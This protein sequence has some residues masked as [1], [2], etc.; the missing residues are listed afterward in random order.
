VEDFAKTVW[1]QLKKEKS[2]KL[3]QAHTHA[4]QHHHKNTLFLKD[5]AW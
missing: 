2:K 1:W 3:N 5:P 4:K